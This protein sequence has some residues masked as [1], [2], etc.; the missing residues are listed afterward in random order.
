MTQSSAWTRQKIAERYLD[1]S[2]IVLRNQDLS[3][4]DLSLT[5]LSNANLSRASFNYNTILPNGGK[6]GRA[7]DMRQFTEP[8]D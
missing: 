1:L 5:N 7:T 8:S 3:G 2:D 6:W 4:V